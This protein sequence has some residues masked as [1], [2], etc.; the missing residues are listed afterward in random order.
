MNDA[1]IVSILVF[2]AIAGAV[3]SFIAWRRAARRTSPKG[4]KP[5]FDSDHPDV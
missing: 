1:L 2:V 3:L 4:E 5:Q